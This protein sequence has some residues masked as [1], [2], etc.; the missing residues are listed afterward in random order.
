M[1]GIAG[2]VGRVDRDALERMSR[3]MAHRG[4]DDEGSWVDDTRSPPVMLASRRLS[5]LDLSAAGHMPM[6]SPDGRYVVVYNGEVYNFRDV[7]RSLEDCGHSFRSGSDTEVLLTAY[8]RWGPDCLHRL[9]G[10]F[11][12]AI[13]DVRERSLFLARDRLGVKPLY[14][15]VDGSTLLFASE[16]K[17]LLASGL[18]RAQVDHGSLATYLQYQFVPWPDTL[19]SGVR[20]LGPAHHATF[21]NG[22]LRV[23]RYWQPPDPDDAPTLSTDELSDLL[24]DAVRLRLISDVPVGLFLSGGIDSSIIASLAA[25]HRQKL[26]SYTVRFAEGGARYDETAAAQV[27]SEGLDL[28]HRIVDCAVPDLG[29]ALPSLI[30]YLD[31]PVGD[32]LVYPFFALS[33]AARS[34]FTVALSGEGADE[35]FHGYRYYTLEAL[36]GR[37]TARLPAALRHRAANLAVRMGTSE[38]TRR[39]AL[40]YVMADTPEAAFHAWAG[41]FFTESQLSE[42]IT[43][44]HFVRSDTPARM[45]ERLPSV[46][47]RD[48]RDISP[49]YDMHFRLVDFILT[50]RDKMSMAVGLEVRSPFLDYRV[51]EAS[52][53]WPAG[54]KIRNQ[55]TK[56]VLRAVAARTLPQHVAQR[57]KI[58]FSSPV[59]LWMRSLTERYL[60]DSELVRDRLL[61]REGV[62]RYCGLTRDG[63][64]RHANRRWSIVVLEIWYRIFVTQSLS[65]TILPLGQP[66]VPPKPSA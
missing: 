50:V 52:F 12:F 1:C 20:K 36:R 25:H 30:W 33:R 5:I 22:T 45:R 61:T 23:R 9:N 4:P 29:E 58:P 48:D 41:A 18:H 27:V 53:G 17:S 32:N 28:D 31:E 66:G 40:A 14:Y 3:S 16:V 7:R 44:D 11:A 35:L 10:M 51:A 57:R 64:D 2:V 19:F 43:P 65:P 6:T 54:A 24:D 15:V 60:V 34:A 49:F 55:E 63:R 37:V 47:L 8:V 42:L 56:R 62:Q 13:W 46:P 39:R 59:H 26:I 21:S 38:S